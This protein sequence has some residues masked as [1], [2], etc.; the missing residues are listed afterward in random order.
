M[1]ASF[2]RGMYGK[3]RFRRFISEAATI[4]ALTVAFMVMVSALVI[5]GLY[6]IF[7]V[8]VNYGLE[9]GQAALSVAGITLA[10][11]IGLALAIRA[12]I[13]K[14]LKKPAA[15]IRLHETVDDTVDAFLNGLLYNERV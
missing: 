3:W 1:L 8:L 12:H 4:A 14:M 7:L 15:S 10:I 13:R 2:G 11:I 9:P 6:G 5:G